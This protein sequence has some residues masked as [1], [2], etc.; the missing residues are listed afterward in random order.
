MQTDADGEIADRAIELETG[1]DGLSFRGPC[2]ADT[3]VGI[4]ACF[5]YQARPLRKAGTLEGLAMPIL[6]WGSTLVSRIMH[7]L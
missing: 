1:R 2:N 4:H 6:V 3:C 5:S 7:A